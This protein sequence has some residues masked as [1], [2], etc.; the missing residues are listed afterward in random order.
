VPFVFCAM[1]DILLAVRARREGS[2]EPIR[3]GNVV[4]LL[5][6]AYGLLTIHGAGA[7]NVTWGFLLLLGGIPFYVLARAR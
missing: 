6:F 7:E 3:A 1:A 5:A 4:A 2:A